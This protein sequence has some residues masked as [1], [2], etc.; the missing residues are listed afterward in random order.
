MV[1]LNADD[2][3]G[4][5]PHRQALQPKAGLPAPPTVI[6]E[7]APASVSCPMDSHC[8]AGSRL[9]VLGQC[10]ADGAFSQQQSAG[11]IGPGLWESG[12]AVQC[13]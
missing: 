8:L 6:D 10:G 1:H 13:Q 9:V 7:A 3:G 2:D 4:N 11:L 12:V 5:L